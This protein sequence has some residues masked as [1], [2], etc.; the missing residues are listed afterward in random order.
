MFSAYVGTERERE[1]E[2]KRE[3]IVIPQIRAAETDIEI[4]RP[5]QK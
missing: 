5:S 1:R 3:G 4:P 2:R